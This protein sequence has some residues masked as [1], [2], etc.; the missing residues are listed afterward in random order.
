ML[1]LKYEVPGN[2]SWS[3]LKNPKKFTASAAYDLYKAVYQ[4]QDVVV[5]ILRDKSKKESRKGAPKEMEKEIKVLSRLVHPN[6]IRLLGHGTIHRMHTYTLCMSYMR[7]S[8][9]LIALCDAMTQ[10]I[11]RIDS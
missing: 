8:I 1:P 4:D 7:I 9:Y 6:I 3:E 11:S 2:V 10:A 5:K